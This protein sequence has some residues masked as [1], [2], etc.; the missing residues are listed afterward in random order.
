MT[1]RV[2]GVSTAATVSR[3]RLPVVASTSANTGSAPTYVTALVVAMNEKDGTTTSL[4]G[5]MPAT[6]NA[7]CKAV[8]QLEVATA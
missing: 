5:P 6:I 1:A 4:A 7:R 3:V 8:V 2:S